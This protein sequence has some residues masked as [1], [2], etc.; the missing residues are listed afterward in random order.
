MTETINFPH[1]TLTPLSNATDPTQQ[2]LEI[3]H[4]EIST[5][6]I[7]VPTKRGDS[8]YG[9]FILVTTPA[10]YTLVTGQAF[11][12]P[13]NPGIAP[14]HL[15]GATGN[16]INETNR[17][18]L[19][20][21]K[22]YTLYANAEAALKKLLL[23]A[24]PD[25]FTEILSDRVLGY[26][27]VSCLT[28]LNHLDTKYGI[29]TEDDLKNNITEM[30]SPFDLQQPIDKLFTRLL[31]CKAFAQAT[32]AITEA[33]M[34][35]AGLTILEDTGAFTI[36]SSDW[37]KKT[38]AQKT[39]VNFQAHFKVADDERRRLMTTRGAGYHQAAQVNGPPPN[40]P[41]GNGPPVQATTASDGWHYCWSHGLT[42]NSEHTSATCSRNAPGHCKDATISNM[43]GG[44][45]Q[46][47][48]RR[49]ES[50]VFVRPPRTT[51]AV[52]ATA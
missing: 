25:T 37:R 1:P 49:G 18:F 23:Q 46:I 22:E 3:L 45:N 6:A 44:C 52:P 42:R 24:V 29:I 20:D 38:T 40:P 31:K 39:F 34:V 17:Q 43:K 50:Q 32:D 7:A 30:N 51:P 4:R 26:A 15:P 36:A 13:L 33:T 35:R 9:H 19:S 11:V 16:Q 14:V 28:I 47:Q 21:D 27:R 12:V 8:S 48:R 10:N 2:T 5:N 41:N